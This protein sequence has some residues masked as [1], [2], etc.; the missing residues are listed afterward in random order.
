LL[1]SRRW[2]KWWSFGQ[3]G[4]S[5]TRQV[6]NAYRYISPLTMRTR[7]AELFLDESTVRWWLP[8][9]EGFSAILQSIR[10]FADERNVTAVSAQSEKLRQIR[11][12]FSKMQI[13]PGSGGAPESSGAG[14]S[15]GGR[16]R[17][18]TA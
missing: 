10:T 18:A 15:G 4:V 3:C 2:G 5:G 7:M 17:D 11:H 8:N 6:L 16:E 14:P 12:V 9:N 13:G 1:C